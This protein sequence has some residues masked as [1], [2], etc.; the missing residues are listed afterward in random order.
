MDPL[1]PSWAPDESDCVSPD[2][3]GTENEDGSF[4][5]RASEVGRL[6]E[7]YADL[8]NLKENGEIVLVEAMEATE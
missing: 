1:I 7:K 4:T 2:E 8:M 6:H 3:G 5:I